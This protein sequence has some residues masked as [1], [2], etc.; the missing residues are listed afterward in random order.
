MIK[1]HEQGSSHKKMCIWVC[2]SKE[3]SLWW[4]GSWNWEPW[5]GSS[6]RE[7]SS[8]PVPHF[9]QHLPKLHQLGI[10]YSSAWHYGLHIIQITIAPVSNCLSEGLRKSLNCLWILIWMISCLR[11]KVFIVEILEVLT[12]M[13]TGHFTSRFSLLPLLESTH[14]FRNFTL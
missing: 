10:K 8:P 4:H 7:Q 14:T 12:G 9:L 3:M 6:K 1:H 13:C 5:A 11:K 2:S